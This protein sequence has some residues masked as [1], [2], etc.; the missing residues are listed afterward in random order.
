MTGGSEEPAG[1]DGVPPEVV[2][3]ALN[4]AT[5]G[6]EPPAESGA[7]RVITPQYCLL[8]SPM[9][10]VNLVEVLELPPTEVPRAVDE[11]RDLLRE[12]GRT[13]AAWSIIS[14]ATGLY[15]QLTS[16]G[17][18][19]YTDPPL[20]P[21]CACM[22]LVQAPNS[23]PTPGVVVREAIE[24]TDF[25][26]VGELAA[27]VFGVGRE[28]RDGFINGMRVRYELH[29]K[30][31][32]PMSTYVAVIDGQVVG[33]AQAVAT[34]TGTN[35]SG[36]SVLPSARG[37]GVYRALV[38]ARWNEAVERGRPALTVQAGDMSRPILERL[39][40]RTVATMLNLRDRFA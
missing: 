23:A 10:T 30:G 22:V 1:L 4:P 37:R 14:T 9:P 18:T 34:A 6:P 20:E 28:D 5:A 36:S 13:Q 24:L 29:R 27:A 7:K 19:P 2:F 32:T 8:M 3:Q 25:L 21:R 31:Q 35:L 39:G 11:V 33:E 38:S 26:A 17:M 16:M 40:F 15:G 12:R